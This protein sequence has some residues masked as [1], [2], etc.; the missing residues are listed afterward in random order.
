MIYKE[1]GNTGKKISAL[2]MGVSRF[3]EEQC[4]SRAGLE[5]CAEVIVS[6]YKH[7]INYFDVAPNYC[8]WKAE[9]ILGIALKQM[10]SD[11]YI[12]D[13]SSSTMDPTGDALRR[14]L[15]NTLKVLGVDKLTFYNMWG[16]LNFEQ[17][18]D[19]IKKGGPL[20]GALRAK[21]EGLIEHIGFSTHCT[22]EEIEKIIEDGYFE[23]VTLG[24]NAINF[25][26]R[27]RG[28]RA[29]KKHGLGV[30]IMNPLYGGVIPQNPKKFDFIRNSEEESVAQA[31]LLFV[32][33]Q[34]GVGTVLS[35]MTNESEIVSNTHVFE[36]HKI[37]PKEKV[38]NI[39]IKIERDFDSLCTGCNYC[40]GCPKG[41]S[42]NKLML[43]YNQ[44]VLT[45]HSINEF[46]QYLY[47][48]WRYY[49][50]D[51]FACVKC[52]RCEKKC[53]QHLNII[54]RI[55][56]INQIAKEYRTAEIEPKLRELFADVAGKK[57]GIYAAG[58]YAKRV[59]DLYKD[60]FGK[61]DF[62]PVFFDSNP[63]K[64]GQ[65]S[66]LEGCIVHSPDEILDTGIEKMYIASTAYYSQIYDSLKNYRETGLQV[67][68]INI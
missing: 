50:E 23:T 24:Y 41:L 48:V 56:E 27:E 2:G 47:D 14:R 25:K 59:F 35:G 51:L 37:F 34:E 22:G 28:L 15:E 49:P 12:T 11:V 68:G 16:I 7:G 21:E 65:E 8:G 26:Y 13:K 9:E 5:A 53:T 61:I 10:G 4:S 32:A 1:F 38:A 17:Y 67:K 18:R 52:G 42:V 36:E 45:D 6:A 63:S 20:E 55:E 40:A 31:A 43:A 64:W 62:E 46:R 60:I 58:P 19:V 30:A 39:K 33:S 44:L 66:I 29:A 57:I 3:S 54:E